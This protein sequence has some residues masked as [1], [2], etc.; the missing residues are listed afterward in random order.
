MAEVY[1]DC[2]ALC[3]EFVPV[4]EV[5][6][7]DGWILIHEFGLDLG[8]PVVAAGRTLVELLGVREGDVLEEET[9]TL[10]QPTDG[11]VA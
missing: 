7:G 11:P 1:D 8:V 6:E 3:D 5:G 9:D 10:G 2:L 4:D